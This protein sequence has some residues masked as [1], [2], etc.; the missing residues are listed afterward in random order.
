M[1][2]KEIEVLM[3]N[4]I[5]FSITVLFFHNAKAAN[6]MNVEVLNSG[7]TAAYSEKER[8]PEPCVDIGDNDP[9]LMQAALVEG[10]YVAAIDSEKKALSDAEKEKEIQKVAKR[11]AAHD[12]LNKI[13]VSKLK[14]SDALS[15]IIDILESR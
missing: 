15:V 5:L 10:E 14:D 7:G 13:D 4:L 6:Y 2:L 11:E 12:R 1:S 9:K 8:C 3:I